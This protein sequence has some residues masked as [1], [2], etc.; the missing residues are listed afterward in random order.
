MY[1][2]KVFERKDLVNVTAYFEPRENPI[3][4]RNHF[5]PSGGSAIARRGC[6]HPDS[7]GPLG[8]HQGQA[9]CSRG[10]RNRPCG[11][12]PLTHLFV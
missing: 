1:K 9:D 12:R 2:S 8:V 11:R 4:R 7:P 6:E 3:S 5:N 10:D